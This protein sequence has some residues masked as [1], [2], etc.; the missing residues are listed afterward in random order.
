MVAARRGAEHGRIDHEES[1]TMFAQLLEALQASC[2]ARRARPR[3]LDE[4]RT[5]LDEADAADERVCGC[6]WFDSSHDL[7][8]GLRVREHT[9]AS[10]EL[11]L[12]LW[13]ELHLAKWR[14]TGAAG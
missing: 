2:P 3:A 4:M 9:A 5:L 14:G 8:Q 7:R 11:P 6:G 1:Q 13:L 10:A 12:P